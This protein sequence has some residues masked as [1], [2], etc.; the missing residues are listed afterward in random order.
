M[1]ALGENSKKRKVS[2]VKPKRLASIKAQS[3]EMLYRP[4]FIPV[5]TTLRSVLLAKGTVAA[6]KGLLAK[7]VEFGIL[8]YGCLLLSEQM[9]NSLYR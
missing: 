3:T 2:G 9:D 5:S 7:V 8:F 6:G 1:R 4:R